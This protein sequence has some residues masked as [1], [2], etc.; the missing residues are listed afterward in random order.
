VLFAVIVVLANVVFPSPNESDDEYTGWYIVLY[1]GLFL[2]FAFGGALNSERTHTLRSGVI[3]G[4][5][6]A[7]RGWGSP[8]WNELEQIQRRI[9][10]MAVRAWVAPLCIPVGVLPVVSCDI[11]W[12]GAIRHDKSYQGPCAHRAAEC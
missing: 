3:G 6:A 12:K 4:A 9:G 8:P 5:S 7:P 1:L 10:A 2:L 11:E